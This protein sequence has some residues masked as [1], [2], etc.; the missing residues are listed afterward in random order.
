ML[1][2]IY[3]DSRQVI[4]LKHKLNIY[5]KQLVDMQKSEIEIK[6]RLDKDILNK[7]M[8]SFK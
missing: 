1:F 8:Y 7:K 5:N 4:K 6:Q 2:I 3:S